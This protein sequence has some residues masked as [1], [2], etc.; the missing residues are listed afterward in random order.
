MQRCRLLRAWA[1]NETAA[2]EISSTAHQKKWQ[3]IVH[4]P[5]QQM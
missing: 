1:N 2:I 4:Q 5:K 3:Y